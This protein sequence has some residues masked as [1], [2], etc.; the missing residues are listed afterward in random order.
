MP[1]T[2]I[3]T[4]TGIRLLDRHVRIAEANLDDIAVVVPPDVHR[5]LLPLTRRVEGLVECNLLA[6]IGI[7]FFG[8]GGFH[9]SRFWSSSMSGDSSPSVATTA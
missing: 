2:E 6:L 4:T 5:A 9:R 1:R 3:L 7:T 8:D